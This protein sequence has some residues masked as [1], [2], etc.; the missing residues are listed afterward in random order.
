M[1]KVESNLLY[2]AAQQRNRGERELRGERCGTGERSSIIRRP[3]CLFLLLAALLAGSSNPVSA[4]NQSQKMAFQVRV[5]VMA[6]SPLVEDAVR[7]R[8]VRDS[9]DAVQSDQITVR[10][11]MA[12]AIAVAALLP[13]RGRA[14]LEVSAAFATSA[15]QGRDDFQNWDVGTV[16]LA[17][18]LLG[19]SFA[20]R[21]S[22]LLH[23][24]VGITKL[25]SESEGMFTKGNGIRP[26]VEAGLSWTT[27]FH[28]ALQ[29]DIRA[30]THT[31]ATGSLRDEDAEEGSV[32]RAVVG[33]SYTL[34][35]AAR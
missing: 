30:Q 29:L 18:A 31:F 11:Q 12:P 15:L 22:L 5:G 17:N 3:L 13:L 2:T 14:E 1:P 25:F 10:Q 9:I 24:G 27:P 16:S 23:G 26:L 28:P 4:Q 35:R 19:V 32:F 20:Y 21:P 8:A 33:G 34:R 6:F 7:S